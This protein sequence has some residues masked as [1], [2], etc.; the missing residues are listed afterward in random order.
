MMMMMDGWMDNGV[1][2]LLNSMK[3]FRR[4]EAH[5]F[6]L[7]IFCKKVTHS[8]HEPTSLTRPS[9]T[10]ERQ[11]RTLIQKTPYK[12]N[13]FHFHFNFNSISGPRCTRPVV[14]GRSVGRSGI[15]AASLLLR[16][17]GQTDERNRTS[18]LSKKEYC[19]NQSNYRYS[20]VPAVMLAILLA[21][22]R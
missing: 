6:I 11:R 17:D 5:L 18:T 4:K 13:L 16:I 15:I 20:P 7:F 9:Q 19:I 2:R 12:V 10:T 8:R 22:S 1:S 3:K 21:D 14:C